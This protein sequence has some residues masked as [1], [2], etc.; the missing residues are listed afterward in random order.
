MSVRMTLGIDLGG[1]SSKATLLDENGKV[2]VTA[3]KEYPSYSLFPGW[4]E[5]DADELFDAVIHNIREIVRLSGI[6]SRNI[7]A[8]AID[9]ATH[10]AVLCDENSRPLRKFIH[11]SDARCGEQAAQLK[12]DYGD[13]LKRYSVNSVSAAW[14]L[15]QL[16]WLKENEPEVLAKTKKIY[17]AK[18]YIRSR[19]TGDFCTDYIEAMGSMLSDDST[20]EWVPELCALVGL[21]SSV[22]PEIR[23]PTDIA[24]YIDS[25]MAELTGLREGTP[26]LVGTTDTVM[27]V[28]AS[29]AIEKGC[30]TVKLATAG[31]ICPITDNAIPSHQF[32]NYKHI[33]PGLWYPGTGTRSCA[34]SYKWYRDVFGTA[35]AHDAEELGISTYDVLNKAAEEVPAGSAGLFFHPYLLGEMT[36]YY[37]DKLRASFTGVG[38]H[39]GKG[40]FSRAVMEGIS[41]SMRD[42]LEEIRAQKIDVQ[43]YRII[44]GGAKGKLWRQI[45]AD[46]LDTELTITKDNDSSLGS[47]MMAGV[48]MGMF[49]DYTESVKKC[50]SVTAVVRPIPQNVEIYNRGFEKY[51]LIQKAL[52]EVY[53]RII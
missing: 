9:A 49:R 44:G 38:M 36:P 53:H 43:E 15:P 42:C 39:H 51:R 28:Y 48:A 52:A 40:H 35:E 11:W 30:A 47:A 7:I 8:L 29:G 34:A 33:I 1:S 2:I 50:T 17:F 23:R 5:Q 13:L 21:E 14:T 32:F 22:L 37:D 46:V 4:L 45:L 27:E 31:R 26:V 6:D 16:L 41:Y 24:G 10:M 3:T 19:F 25:A 12:A 20:A 18:D